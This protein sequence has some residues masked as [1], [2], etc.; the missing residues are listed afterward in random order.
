MASI[1]AQKKEDR[2]P[3]FKSRLN[4]LRGDMPQNAFAEK[5]GIARATVGFYE[6]G[7]RLPD[8]LI[9]KQI[10]D[11]TGVSTDWLLG[12]TDDKKGNADVEAV[13]ARLGFYPKVQ[14]GFERLNASLDSVLI[15][16]LEPISVDTEGM[17][18][19]RA[20]R[21]MDSAKIQHEERIERIKRSQHE[22]NTN[23]LYMFNKLFSTPTD[24]SPDEMYGQVLLY[25]IYQY[26]FADIKDIKTNIEEHDNGYS[27]T[28]V[29]NADDLRKA[30]LLQ[31]NETITKFREAVGNNG[32][33]TKN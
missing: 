14:M 24:K 12:R 6:N 23:V 32:K 29:I 33:H 28:V 2:L 18:E 13:V 15:P 11:K 5:I 4:E 31:I 20:K 9:L 19:E 16:H 25:M 10:A 26:C 7:E 17:S 22:A 27:R 8:A 21:L 30:F 1:E 3:E